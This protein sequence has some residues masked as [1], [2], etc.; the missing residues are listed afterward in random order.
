[1][2]ALRAGKGVLCKR[3]PS[4]NRQAAQS[5]FDEADRRGKP[6][7]CGFYNPD[8]SGV[9]RGADFEWVLLVLSYVSANCQL[10]DVGASENFLRSSIVC[11]PQIIWVTLLA[12]D[13]SLGGPWL[14]APCWVGICWENGLRGMGLPA[15]FPS[16]SPRRFDP[17]FQFLHKQVCVGHALGRIHGITAISSLF[18]AASPAS[19][20]RAAPPFGITSPIRPKFTHPPC[21]T[22]HYP[23]PS[24]VLILAV[25]ICLQSLLHM[26]ALKDADTVM[27]SM[28]FPCGAV[29][30]VDV[31]QHRTDL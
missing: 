8:D 15:S 2:H 16:S 4:L 14:L 3:L 11:K 12:T 25:A 30:S 22:G 1:M 13:W 26:A 7:V 23:D 24:H 18:P 29:V 10:G 21:S 20:K 9:C 28:K 31:S 27:I 6:L 17:A 19:L 5:C